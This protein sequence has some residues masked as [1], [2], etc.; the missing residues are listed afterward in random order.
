MLEFSMTLHD[1]DVEVGFSIAEGETV[2]V[3]GPNG[4]GKSTVLSVLAGLIRP[5]RAL[6]RLDSTWLTSLGPEPGKQ[7]HLPPHRRRVALL[8]QDPLLFPHLGVRENVAFGPRSL[9][10][11]RE[12]AAASAEQWL[13][14]VE[15]SDLADRMP[16]ELS[17]GQ[18]QRVA[19]AR[20]LAADPRLLLLDEPMA[21]LDIAVAPSL[22]QTL[23]R[24]LADRSA[25]IVTHDVLD[26]FL[27][28]DRV[29]VLDRG[30]VVETGRT[31]EV[32]STPR[33]PFSARLSGLNMVVGT[34]AGDHARIGT[35]PNASTVYGVQAGV[36]PAPGDQ[37]AATF[38]PHAVAVYRERPHGSP[39]NAFEVTVTAVEPIGDLFR[40]RAGELS[41]DVTAQAVVEMDL[42][43]GAAVTF[44][45]KA[46]EVAIYGF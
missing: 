35:E 7:V 27:L 12:Q 9:G 43:T 25:I 42:A 28:A 3:L 19:I 11:G 44:L 10:A 15:A 20:A 4:A 2:A 40:I 6:V 17:G 5:D 8:A 23:R 18:A 26:A 45:V 34:W 21:A 16:G 39:R 24:V 29:V 13:A 41:A 32:L 38:R 14:E 22:R 36:D 31:R 37:V 30:R 1:R 33:T 46:T